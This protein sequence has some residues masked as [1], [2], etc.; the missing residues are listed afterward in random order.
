MLVVRN[1]PGAAGAASAG[2]VVG[3]VFFSK[4]PTKAKMETRHKTR[5]ESKA[6]QTR[7]DRTKKR[8]GIA[9]TAAMAAAGQR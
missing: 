7:Q 3:V 6:N 8:R 4:E 2:A 1:L 5:T 9:H